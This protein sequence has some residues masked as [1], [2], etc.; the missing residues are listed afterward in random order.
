M[1]NKRDS[2]G[3][4]MEGRWWH[5]N[6]PEMKVYLW[7]DV[8]LQQFTWF[9]WELL[10]CPCRVEEVFEDGSVV[11]LAREGVLQI[12]GTRSRDKETRRDLKNAGA[13]FNDLWGTITW[14][15]TGRLQRSL[16]LSSIPMN[17]LSIPLK[18]KPNGRLEAEIWQGEDR[19]PEKGRDSWSCLEDQVVTQQPAWIGQGR[20]V[21]STTINQ[22]ATGLIFYL[23]GQKLREIG[24][25]ED[26]WSEALLEEPWNFDQG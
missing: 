20:S 24:P 9:G 19:R 11:W 21:S 5:N 13:L 15:P 25:G 8:T 1:R 3:A 18:I 7:K 22:L 2:V 14:Q 12:A 4:K 23:G 17:G 10:L 6:Q 16:S 26:G